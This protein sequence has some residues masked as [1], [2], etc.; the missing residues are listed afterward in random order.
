MCNIVFVICWSFY[1]FHLTLFCLAH[2]VA[3]IRVFLVN[4]MMQFHIFIR[5]SSVYLYISIQRFNFIFIRLSSVYSYFSILR[6]NLMFIHHSS[7]YLKC[8]LFLCSFRN[9]NTP[10]YW[11]MHLVECPL[12][13]TQTIFIFILFDLTL[14]TSFFNRRKERWKC[15]NRFPLRYILIFLGVHK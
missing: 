6:F 12:Y 10:S 15:R 5:L 14:T 2:W 11:L 7:V 9:L 8:L 3:W 4:S 1:I 13:S